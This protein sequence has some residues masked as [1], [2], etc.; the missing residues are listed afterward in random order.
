MIDTTCYESHMRFPTAMKLFWESVE[1]LYRYICQ[2]CRVLGI[3]RLRN[4]YT[5]VAKSYLSYYKKRKRKASRARMLKRRMIRL[6]E[7]LI[8]Q[9][10]EIHSQY[11]TS[12]RYTRDCQ[13]CFPSSERFFYR[14]R[15]CLKAGKSVTVLSALTVIIHV[16]L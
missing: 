14:K 4:K 11:G 16:P 13:K 12:L 2:H 9:R 15:K 10:D 1:W 8:M 5:D 6:Q 7:K 3:R